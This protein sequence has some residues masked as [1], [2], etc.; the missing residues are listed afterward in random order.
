[1]TGHRNESSLFKDDTYYSGQIVKNQLRRE[2]TAMSI[3]NYYLQK[4]NIRVT[5]K[6]AKECQEKQHYNDILQNLSQAL[7]KEK[8]DKHKSK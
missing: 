5:R 1:M 7:R 2:K 4:Q 3:R 8:E 6:K